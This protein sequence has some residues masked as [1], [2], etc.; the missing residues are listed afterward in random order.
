MTFV[1]SLGRAHSEALA[2]RRVCEN[3]LMITTCESGMR[4]LSSGRERG[5]LSLVSVVSFFPE[6]RILEKA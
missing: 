5:V 4:M 1:R 6:T 2:D 3:P